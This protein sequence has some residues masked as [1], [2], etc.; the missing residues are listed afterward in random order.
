VRLFEGCPGAS[1][2][3]NTAHISPAATQLSIFG[4][5]S[6]QATMD[7][8]QRLEGTV[9][10]AI[11][12]PDEATV[13]SAGSSALT[14]ALF[15]ASVTSGYILCLTVIFNAV[16]VASSDAYVANIA[17][18]VV[19]VGLILESKTRSWGLDVHLRDGLLNT[20]PAFPSSANL[21]YRSSVGFLVE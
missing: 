4:T 16:G 20:S 18:K 3:P 14:S 1:P 17:K 13:R 9:I 15:P 6:T 5:R 12:S 2:P 11:A 21:W 19:H 8:V 10:P 7:C